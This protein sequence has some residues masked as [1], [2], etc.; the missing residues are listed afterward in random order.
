MQAEEKLEAYKCAKKGISQLSQALIIL[1][2]NDLGFQKKLTTKINQL[3]DI[4]KKLHLHLISIEMLEKIIED[5]PS[6]HIG[7]CKLYCSTIQ[8]FDSFEGYLIEAKM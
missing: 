8:E 6:L 7:E 4:M 3:Q 1:N 2:S 5:S